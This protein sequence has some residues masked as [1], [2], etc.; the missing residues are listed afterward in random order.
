MLLSLGFPLE[1]VDEFNEVELTI[2]GFQLI[3]V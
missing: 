1:V 2:S 3:R